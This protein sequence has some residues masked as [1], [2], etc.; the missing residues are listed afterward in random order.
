MDRQKTR[1]VGKEILVAIPAYN[2]EATIGS[3]VLA[4][5]QYSDAVLVVDD[6]SS[7]R[8]VDLARQAGATVIEQ[9]TN[10]GKGNAI[11]RAFEFAQ[12]QDTEQLA[13]LDGDWQ[14]DPAEM[15]EL[16][17]ALTNTDADIVIGSRYMDG[18]TGDTPLYRRFGQRV[19]DSLTYL[20]S[21]TQVSDSQS[22]YRVFNRDAIEQLDINTDGF[23]VETEMLRTANEHGLTVAE[24]PIS[25][26]YDVPDANTSNS[27]FHGLHVVDTFLRIVR[28]RHPL[29]FFGIPGLT[30]MLLGLLYGGWTVSLYQSGGGFYIGKALFSAV[31]FI[32]GTF[33]VFSAL[34]MNMIGRR[35]ENAV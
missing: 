23:G 2:E 30:M 34:I 22:G 11:Q 12:E 31:L 33:A 35:L 4:A 1:S 20:S 21:G 10:M 8:T 27:L 26:R 24:A 3:V 9:P 28:D 16:L 18:D 7:D 25:V 19:L 29:L 32:I 13:I 5:R 15:S 6:G 14:H 17:D